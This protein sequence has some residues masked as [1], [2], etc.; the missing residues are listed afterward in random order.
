MQRAATVVVG[1]LRWVDPWSARPRSEGLPGVLRFVRTVLHEVA[2]LG[3]LFAGYKA[4]RLA[5]AG[6]VDE[7]F[8]NAR[9]VLELERVLHLDYEHALQQAV[10]HSEAV[11]TALNRFYVSMHF[12]TMVVFLLWLFVRHRAVYQHVRR[13][14]IASTAAALLLHAL[15]PL[16]PPRMLRGFVDTMAVYG[17]NAYASEQV[18][19]VANQHAAMPSVHFMWAALV[20]Y[21]IV[22]AVRSRWRWLAVVHPAVTLLAIVATA[23]HYWLDAAVGAGL[24]V[25]AVA[26]CDLLRRS[27]DPLEAG[28]AAALDA[29]TGQAPVP[30]QATR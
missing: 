13:I 21:G 28:T 9:S 3:I 10:L 1:R 25:G 15:F 22:L 5:V 17:P 20:T 7:A 8:E 30:R 18:N 12:S 26:L 6:R 11:I 29:V 19:A 14:L 16:A 2:L 24:V 27:E 23:N 4:V